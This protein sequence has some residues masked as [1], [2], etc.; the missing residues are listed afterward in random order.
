MRQSG[1]TQMATGTQ[2]SNRVHEGRLVFE[3]TQ[4]DGPGVWFSF[5]GETQ[6]HSYQ[7]LRKCR[8]QAVRKGTL[9]NARCQNWPERAG[10]QHGNSARTTNAREQAA[11]EREER[12]VKRPFPRSG[13]G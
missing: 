5:P 12:L 4:G 13:N 6:V 2:E 3:G 10:E 7:E 9:P 11:R 8:P 1:A